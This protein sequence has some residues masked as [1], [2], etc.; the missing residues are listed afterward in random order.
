MRF[1]YR[2]N[3]NAENNT[4]YWP[5]IASLVRTTTDYGLIVV[6]LEKQKQKPKKQQ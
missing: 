4:D 3:K 2:Q 1:Q 5:S 6:Q